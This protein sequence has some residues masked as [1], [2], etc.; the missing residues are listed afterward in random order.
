M[1]FEV[2]PEH[3]EALSDSD[4]RTLVGYLA[5]QE[6][7]RAGHSPAGV[8]YGGHQ[9]AKDGGLD[10][11]VDL[12]D[13]TINGYVPRLQSGFQVK[14]EDM[15]ASAIQKEMSPEGKLRS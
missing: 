1:I 14:A 10:V 7:V 8:T 2:T 9:N 6:A 5:E 4:L 12:K 13:G 15:P 3:I 11:R